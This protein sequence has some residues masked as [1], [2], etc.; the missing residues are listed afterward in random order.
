MQHII[1]I[2]SFILFTTI[3]YGQGSSNITL[4]GQTMTD[5]VVQAMPLAP[6]NFPKALKGIT[7]IEQQYSGV[8]NYEQT[9]KRAYYATQ[10]PN[11]ILSVSLDNILSTIS[12]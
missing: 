7:A 9:Y 6:E 8:M 10:N 11:D 12:F 5:D 2:T 1:K 4:L 3:I